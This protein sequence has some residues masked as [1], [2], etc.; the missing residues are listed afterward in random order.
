MTQNEYRSLILID[1]H[2]EFICMHRS[3]IPLN[4]KHIKKRDRTYNV[5]QIPL[6]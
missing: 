2:K 3:G 5:T 1:T 6:R 4:V